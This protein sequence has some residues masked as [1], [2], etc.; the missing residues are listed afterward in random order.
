MALAK[1]GARATGFQDPAALFA[2][3]AASAEMGDIDGAKRL[4]ESAVVLVKAGRKPGYLP[5]LE[6]A[7]RQI[8]ARGVVRMAAPQWEASLAVR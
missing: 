2:L 4:L 7:F 6:E 1:Q 3:S 8:E 5:V